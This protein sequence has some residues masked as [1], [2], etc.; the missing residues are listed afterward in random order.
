MTDWRRGEFSVAGKYRARSGHV[1]NNVAVYLLIHVFYVY[2]FTYLLDIYLGVELLGHRVYICSTLV[3]SAKQ[4]SKRGYINLQSYQK[5]VQELPCPN[6]FAT[7]WYC[8]LLTFCHF[9]WMWG[10]ISW[11]YFASVWWLFEHLFLQISSFS[12]FVNCA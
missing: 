5:C 6:T 2:M 1:T 8:Q 4:F 3:D 11:Y 10:S 9:W 7:T 12:Y